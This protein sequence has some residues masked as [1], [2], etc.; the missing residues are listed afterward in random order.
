MV[1]WLYDE[2]L[3]KR[4]IIDHKLLEFNKTDVWTLIG[5]PEKEDGNLSHYEYFCIHDDIFDIIQST[6]QHR[7]ILWK[8]ISNEPNE[9][10]SQS[11][12]KKIHYG[13]I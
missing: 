1:V 2:D 4:F 11:G 5:I 7:N 6:R 13:K 10:G 8:F 9:N 12:A 3:K